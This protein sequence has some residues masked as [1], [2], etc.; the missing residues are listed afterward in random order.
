MAEYIER[1]DALMAITMAELPDKTENG[2]PIANGKRSVTDCIR[3]IRAIPSADVQSV[4]HGKWINNTI[5][6]S[7]GIS[8]YNFISYNFNDD[9]GYAKPFGTWKYCPRCGARMDGEM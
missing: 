9:K 5:C 4:K 1:V 2:I 7:C 3:R 8:K 6:A